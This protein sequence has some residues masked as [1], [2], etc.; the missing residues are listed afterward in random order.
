M[1]GKLT[2]SN[3]SYLVCQL[4]ADTCECKFIRLG[5]HCTPPCKNSEPSLSQVSLCVL[6]QISKPA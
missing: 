5:R 1:L 6:S 4:G 2:D 3:Y